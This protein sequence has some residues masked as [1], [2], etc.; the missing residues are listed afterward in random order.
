[1]ENLDESSFTNLNG[2]R[3]KRIKRRFPINQE[4]KYKM[5]YG[6]RIAVNRHRPNGEPVERGRLVQYRKHAHLRAT[7]GTLAELA[8]AAERF[9][10]HEAHDLW[11]RGGAQQRARRRGGNRALR[12]PHVTS[13]DVSTAAGS[14]FR[15]TPSAKLEFRPRKNGPALGSVTCRPSAFSAP[16]TPHFTSPIY[17]HALPRDTALVNFYPIFNQV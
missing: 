11:L 16:L 6:Q 17:L 2:E 10:P 13:P 1:M 4:V 15:G 7:R 12:V 14:Q 3:E 9:L 5:L 8:R